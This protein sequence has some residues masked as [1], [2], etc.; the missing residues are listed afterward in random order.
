MPA[1]KGIVGRGFTAADFEQ[2]VQTIKLTL[3]HPQF[4]VL[5]NTFIPGLRTGIRF[6]ASSGCKTYNTI[7]VTRSIG[8][9]VLICS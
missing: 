1:W 9:L 3:W 8:P 2:Y 6:Q 7:T 5:H 4:V